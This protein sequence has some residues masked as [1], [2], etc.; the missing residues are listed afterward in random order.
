[1]NLRINSL[2]EEGNDRELSQD[3]IQEELE[4]EPLVFLLEISYILWFWAL[5]FLL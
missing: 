1:M 4:D 2:Q 5:S 3:Y